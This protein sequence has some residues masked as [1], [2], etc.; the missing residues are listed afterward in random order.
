MLWKCGVRHPELNMRAYSTIAGASITMLLLLA[1]FLPGI[2]LAA[3]HEASHEKIHEDSDGDGLTDIDE[4][5]I[6]RTDSQLSD[7]DLDGLPDGQE[8]NE[9]WTLPLVADT[10]GDGFL[11]GVEVRLDSDPTEADS[12]PDPKNPKIDDL[13]GDGLSNA[14]EREHGT[15]P[16]HVDTDFDGLNDAAEIREYFTNPTLMDSDG[17]GIWDGD[18]VRAGTDPANAEDFVPS[19]SFGTKQDADSKKP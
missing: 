7:T 10:D 4:A 9:Y 18:E 12:L 17:D 5:R 1:V 14:E 8:V 16:Q 19:R 3:S 11:D 15:N 2:T 6:Y 13:D